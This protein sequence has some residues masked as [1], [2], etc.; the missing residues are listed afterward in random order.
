MAAD[1]HDRVVRADELRNLALEL[2]VHRP[3]AGHDAAR[4]HRAPPARDRLL[5]RERDVGIAGE[6]E[7][8]VVRKVEQT[9]SGD[10]RLPARHSLVH[11]EERIG[12]AVVA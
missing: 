12:D 2:A 9:P 3:L 7:V 11:V 5:R 8:V 1:V 6:T 4:R 10:R